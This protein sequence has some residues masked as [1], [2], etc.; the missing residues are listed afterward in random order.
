MQTINY[1]GHVITIEQDFFVTNP[2][3]DQ[4]YDNLGTLACFHKNY[5]SDK[6]CT[7][8]SNDFNTLDK[9]KKYITS[10]AGLNAIC[11]PVY[12]YS[13]SGDTIKT[14]PFNCRWDSGQ[15]GFIYCSKEKVRKD[16][17]W[18]RITA[19]R[20]EK[21]KTFLINEIDMFDKYIRDDVYM[22]SITEEGDDEIIDSMGEY[23]DIDEC[24]A[25]AKSMCDMYTDYDELKKIS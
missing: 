17:R 16:M 13:H 9:I 14:T 2:R 22:A 18:K 24:I 25:Q 1:K 21:V 10:R 12:L 11:L 5:D 19:K 15:L 20:L 6:N 3:D 8:D 7:I 23:Y 4:N